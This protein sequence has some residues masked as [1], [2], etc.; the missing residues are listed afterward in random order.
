MNRDDAVRE[1]G[2][3]SPRKMV[4]QILGFLI[5][6]IIQMAN[7]GTQMTEAFA[8]LDRTAELLSQPGEDDDPRRSDSMP[9]IQGRVA[10]EGVS[11]A[12]EADKPVLRDISPDAPKRVANQFAKVAWPAFGLALVTGIW[13]L[14]EIES[15]QSTEYNITLGIKLLLVAVAGTSAAVHSLTPSPAMRGIA[16][17]LGLF[18]SLGVVVLGVMLVRG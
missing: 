4:V 18:G 12:Y 2:L 13:N 10:F 9:P 15:G 16:G 5:G 8:G 17:A 11:F 3:F 1:A 6:P 14:L 7:I